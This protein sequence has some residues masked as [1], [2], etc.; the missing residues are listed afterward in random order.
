[1]LDMKVKETARDKNSNF[2]I[3]DKFKD[4]HSLLLTLQFV[5]QE[6]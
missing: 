4:L 5:K 1:M 6:N 2:C 3:Q